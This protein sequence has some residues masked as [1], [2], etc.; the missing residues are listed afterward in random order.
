MLADVGWQGRVS[1]G[2]IFQKTTLRAK[3]VNDTLGL[4]QTPLPGRRMKVTYVLLADEA[5]CV[6]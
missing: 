1:D 3:I 4:P 5:F 2:R 6:T